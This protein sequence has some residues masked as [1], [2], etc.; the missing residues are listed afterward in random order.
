MDE[1]VI[2]ADSKHP[3]KLTVGEWRAEVELQLVR[4]R[5]KKNQSSSAIRVG[6]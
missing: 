5:T 3:P 6:S 2:V 1:I 4:M